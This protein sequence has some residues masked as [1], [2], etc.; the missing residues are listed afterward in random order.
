MTGTI[1]G[2]HVTTKT[3]LQS[4]H[5]FECLPL[6]NEI[7]NTEFLGVSPLFAGHVFQASSPASQVEPAR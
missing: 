7:G 4:K 1:L 3:K 2:G 6:R 5:F